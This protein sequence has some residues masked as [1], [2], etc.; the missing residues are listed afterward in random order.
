MHDF[1]NA[2]TRLGSRNFTCESKLL[3]GQ[4][5]DR[6]FSCKDFTPPLRKKSRNISIWKTW[7]V[8]AKN[9]WVCEWWGFKPARGIHDLS[10]AKARTK[11]ATTYIA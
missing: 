3:E 10:P 6:I 9:K 11:M 7:R 5:S 1:P 4:R 2:Y 8:S